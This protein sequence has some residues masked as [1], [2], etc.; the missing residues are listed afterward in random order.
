MMARLTLSLMVLLSLPV[1]AAADDRCYVTPY[2]G[3]YQPYTYDTV[4]VINRQLRLY[5]AKQPQKDV[6]G[7][8]VFAMEYQKVLDTIPITPRKEVA[9]LRRFQFVNNTPPY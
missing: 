9:P 8:R 1:L 2:G 3:Y 7:E 6:L 5:P 4:D